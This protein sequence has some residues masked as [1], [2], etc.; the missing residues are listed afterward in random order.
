MGAIHGPLPS[1]FLSKEE[2]ATLTGSHRVAKQETILRDD[3]LPFRRRGNALLVSRHHLREWLAG[4]LVRVGTGGPRL[5]L[6]R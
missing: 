1:E 4:R 3:G 2:L 6:V 5:D